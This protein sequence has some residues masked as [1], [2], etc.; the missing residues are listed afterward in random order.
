LTAPLR[1]CRVC[2]TQLPKAE[3]NRWVI[4]E[5]R[6]VADDRQKLPG[7]GYYTCSQPRCAELL[8][9]V[10]KIKVNA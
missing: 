7:R 1:R 10:L 3:L 8:T 6:L 4:R 9:K 2:R 5:G